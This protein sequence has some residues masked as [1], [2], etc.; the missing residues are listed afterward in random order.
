[1]KTFIP[2]ALLRNTVLSTTASFVTFI[3]ISASSAWAQNQPELKSRPEDR[4]LAQNID[5]S[6]DQ[7]LKVE[8]RVGVNFQSGPGVGYDASFGGLHFFV[9]FGQIPEQSTFYTAGQVNLFTNDDNFNGNLRLGYRTQ[10]PNN[11]LVLGGYVGW[12][13]NQTSSD[14]TFHQMGLGADLQGNKWIVSTNA[15]LPVGSTRREVASSVADN[16]TTFS[17]FRFSGNNLLYSSLNQQTTTRLYEAAMTGVDLEAGYELLSWD[18]GNLYGYGGVYFLDASGTSSVVGGRGRLQVA[19]DNFQGGL[20][21]QSDDNFGTTVAVNLGVTFGGNS[22]RKRGET[23]AGSLVARLGNEV[24]RR[25]VI[26][27][28]QQTATTFSLTQANNL[29]ARNPATGQ[30]WRFLHV[31]D[32]VMGGDGTFETP[33]G[34]VTD[35]TAIA[36]TAGN[37][38]IYVEAGDRTGL[39]GFTIPDNVQVLSTGVIQALDVQDVGITPLPG[40]GSGTLPLVNSTVT[41]GNGT[42]LSGFDVKTVETSGIYARNVS[43]FTIDRNQVTTTAASGIQSNAL[44][45]EVVNN[46]RISDN[47]VTTIGEGARAIDTSASNGGTISNTTISGNSIATTGIRASG[48]DNYA[49]NGGTIS[50]SMITGNSITTTELFSYGII[51]DA[52][53]GG[54]IS[55]T[56]ITGNTISTSGFFTDGILELASDGTISRATISGNTIETTGIGS[57]GIY[58]YANTGG[59][60]RDTTI[61]GNTLTTTRAISNGIAA[62]S[63]NGEISNTTISGNTITTAGN[64][65]NGIDLE[66]YEGTLNNTTISGNTITTTGSYGDGIY[67]YVYSGTLNN[68]TIS[69]NTVST[70]GEGAQGIEFAIEDAGTMNN[71]TITN[72]QIQQ[73]GEHSVILQTNETTSNIC[74]TQFSGNTSGGPNTFSAGGNDLNIIVEPGSTVDFVNF[75]N[76]AANN[77]GF[78][79]VVGTPSGQPSTCP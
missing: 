28:D 15:Y 14:E 32:G 42:T 20:S 39:A 29:I 25:H 64:N 2:D 5:G 31:T 24:Q 47:S 68:P 6:D 49:D 62:N 63:Y 35:G 50:N 34:A 57:Q 11:E 12:D 48:I 72:N 56:T 69:G 21:V 19:V 44:A 43:D 55:D 38:V 37:D 54:T 76:V 61:S 67:A 4:P 9:P 73:A 46:A 22:H 27:I 78:D 51:D 3:G 75:D 18:Q 52:Y 36:A 41:M 53:N 40:S 74:V 33:L 65:A 58:V 30:T 1:M 59:T 79:D 8:P 13:V 17:D 45:G 66:T 23:S 60:I 10:L 26:A 71:A 16:G 77:T 7:P 70:I